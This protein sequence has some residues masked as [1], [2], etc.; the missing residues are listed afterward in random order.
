MKPLKEY[1]YFRTELGVQYL[2]DYK[3]VLPL[4]TDKIDLICIDPPYNIAFHSGGGSLGYKREKRKPEIDGIGSNEQFSITEVL[5]NIHESMEV[6]C[7][8]VWMAKNSL[9]DC[10]DWIRKHSYNWDLLFWAKRN[11]LPTHWN[12]FLPDIE[13]CIF[14]RKPKLCYFNNELEFNYYRHVM[15]DTVQ[16]LKGHPTPK[17]FWM[18][19]KEIRVSTKKND[20]VLDCFGGSGTTAMACE[21]TKRRWIQIE[22]LEKYCE[23]SKIRISKERNQLPLLEA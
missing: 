6:F 2:G 20:L 14:I 4:I 23:L 7:C 21:R 3:E 1:E 18:I 9:P 12:G 8:Y 16:Q 17:P 5:D 19:K 22:L 10:M 13:Y 15:V 11:P